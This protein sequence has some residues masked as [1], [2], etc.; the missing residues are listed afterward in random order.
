MEVLLRPDAL[1]QWVSYA[2]I[3]GSNN[4]PNIFGKNGVFIL[5]TS[6]NLVLIWF[7][8]RVQSA[9]DRT[10]L[11]LGDMLKFVHIICIWILRISYLEGNNSAYRSNKLAARFPRCWM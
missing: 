1:F 10:V 4:W 8:Q 5:D 11:F 3:H 2:A 9:Q 7:V 6:N